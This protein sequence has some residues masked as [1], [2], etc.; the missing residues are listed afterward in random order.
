MLLTIAME[1]PIPELAISLAI[2][3]RAIRHGTTGRMK[4]ELTT[5]GAFLIAMAIIFTVPFLFWRLARTNRFAP[6]VIVQIV[7]GILLGPAFVGRYFPDFHGFLFTGSVLQALNGIAWWA[8]TLF[9]WLAGIELDLKQAWRHRRESLTTAGLALALPLLFG[10]LVAVVLA[11]D[12]LWLGPAASVWQFTIGVGMA[13]AVTALPILI[14]LLENLS[15]L[16]APIGQRVLRYASLDDIAIWGVLALVLVDFQRAGLQCGF[17]LAF[18]ACSIGFRRLMPRLSG[19]DRWYVGVLWLVLSACAAE[20]AGLHFMI[21]AFLA[22]AATD[23]GWFPEK[24]MDQF[25]QSILLFL[26]PVYFL[27]AG[28]RTDWGIDGASVIFA[29]A[30]LLLA[31]VSGKL[32]GVWIAGR[33]LRWPAGEASM[34]GWLLQTKAL[35]MIVFASVLLDTEIIARK[36]FT[37][38]LLMA[39]VSTLLTVPIVAPKLKRLGNASI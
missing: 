8:V 24:Q 21:G 2:G 12:R 23:A 20:W 36:T 5:T 19:E 16:R 14:L 37:A 28:L 25:R 9:V 1:G 3:G 18:A 33:I 32:L 31:A 34:I 10:S 27:S 30:A 4:A 38:L 22:G 7:A 6:L 29:A 39:I 35:V 26:M 13:C 11:A 15:I 17:L